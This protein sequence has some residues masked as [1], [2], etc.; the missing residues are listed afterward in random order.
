MVDLLQAG[1]ASGG[2]GVDYSQMPGSAQNPLQVAKADYESTLCSGDVK[3][4]FDQGQ[5]NKKYDESKEEL[6]NAYKG[7]K[8]E[9]A[10]IFKFNLSGSGAAPKCFDM[11]SMGGKSYS[12]C[13]QVDGYWEILAAIMIFIFYFVALMIVVRR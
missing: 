4:F 2:A 1:Q 9:V 7:I 3:Y 8:E 10:D 11:F 12:V 13:P 5:I 6:K